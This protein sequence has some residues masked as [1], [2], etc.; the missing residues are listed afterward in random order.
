MEELGNEA[1][2]EE[3]DKARRVAGD[4]GASGLRGL[5]HRPADAPKQILYPEK[6]S[7]PEFLYR[8][9]ECVFAFCRFRD[10]I[11]LLTADRIIL[12]KQIPYHRFFRHPE[13][14]DAELRVRFTVAAADMSEL[15]VIHSFKKVG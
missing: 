5:L 10:I 4:P 7:R 14:S 1:K 11:H 8:S 3:M 13:A 9:R 12:I 2:K 15:D 6:Q